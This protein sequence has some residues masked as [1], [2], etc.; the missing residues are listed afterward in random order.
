MNFFDKSETFKFQSL[1]Q[2]TKLSTLQD[3]VIKA[4]DVWLSLTSNLLSEDQTPPFSPTATIREKLDYGQF[5][6]G[7]PSEPRCHLLGMQLSMP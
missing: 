4:C 1:L 5:L 7:V 6:A 2:G 3:A